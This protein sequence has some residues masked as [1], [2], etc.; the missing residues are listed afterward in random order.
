MA[1]RDDR[2]VL[3]Q[4]EANELTGFDDLSVLRKCHAEPAAAAK[5][6]G[7]GRSTHPQVPPCGRNDIGR[8]RPGI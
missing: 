8:F 3:H 1:P 6:L 2:L 4:V 7:L 5:Y